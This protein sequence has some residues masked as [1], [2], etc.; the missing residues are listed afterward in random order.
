MTKAR[1]IMNTKPDHCVLETPVQDLIKRFAEQDITGILVVD[2]EQR[3]RGVITE[4]DLVDQQASLHVPTALTIFDMVLPVGEDRFERELERIQALTAEDLMVVD[5]KT[6]SPDSGLDEI[7]SLMAE[8]NVHHL[9]V[10]EGDTIEGMLSKHDVIKALA[11][12]L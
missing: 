11:K 7:A 8:A 3:L 6:L 10:I 4:S 2:D 1:D 9:P 12:A 5:V